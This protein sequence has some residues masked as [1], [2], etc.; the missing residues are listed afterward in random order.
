MRL[1]LITNDYPPKPG[2]IQMYLQNLVDAWPGEVLVYGPQDDA[3]PEHE[4]LIVRGERPYMLPTKQVLADVIA[5]AKPFEPEAV[6]FG[7]PHP[8]PRLGP[9]LRV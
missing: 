1:L 9:G 5:A 2:G 4:D 8:L 3:A 7:A 6:L